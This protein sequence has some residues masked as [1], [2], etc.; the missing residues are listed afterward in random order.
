MEKTSS[1]TKNYLRHSDGVLFV[2]DISNRDSFEDL[3][4]WYYLYKEEKIEVVGLLI[5]NKCDKERQVDHNEVKNFADK[6]KLEYFETSAKL[7]K[8]IKKAI[9]SL[10]DK[11]IN[12]HALYHSYST[13]SD[14]DEGFKIEPTQLKKES[15]CKKFCR[16]LNFL[17]GS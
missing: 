12:S 13:E 1:I 11:I 5:G 7:D 15:W 10:L 3:N 16:K 4:K 6:N 2:Y 14:K 9:V 17:I 8:N